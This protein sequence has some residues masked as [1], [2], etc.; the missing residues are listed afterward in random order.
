MYHRHHY[1][2]LALLCTVLIL[3]A[4]AGA[5]PAISQTDVQATVDA[6]VRA[7]LAAQPT[8]PQ[9]PTSP[10]S[11]T[12]IP[13]TATAAPTSPPMAPTVAPFTPATPTETGADTSTATPEATSAPTDTTTV[14]RPA[15]GEA[16]RVITNIQLVFDASGSMA[17]RIGNETK[18]QAAQRAIERIID[19]LPDS[20]DL[21]VGFRVFG[22]EGDS[23]EA[24]KARSCQS[25]AL[26]VPVQGVN[27]E[28][29]RQQARAWKPA[30]WTPI[31]LALQKAGEDL[32]PGEHVRNVIIMVTDG[33]ETCGGDPCAVAKA[34]AESQAEVRIDVVGFGLTPDVAKT[35][36]CVAENSGGVYTDAQDGNALV[37]TL[38]E[39]I[40]ATIK[41]STLRFVPVGIG[42]K[43]EEVALTSLTNV[44]GENVLTA[45]QLPWMARFAR[46][47]VVELPPGEYRF[48]ISYIEIG[49][50]Q[51][52]QH[53]ATTY[54]AI[55]EEG[56][57]TV[58]VI[59]R[60]GVTFVN[61]TP[62]LLRSADLQVEK[63]VNGQWEQSIYPGQMVGI[64]SYFAFDRAFRLTPGRYR[65][66][67]RKRKVVLIDNLIVEPGKEITVRLRGE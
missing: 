38:E 58:A 19:T 16:A 12:T 52:A 17:Q 49:G 11:P 42:G 4:C 66:Y 61:E 32:Q 47:Q 26:L 8:P 15:E 51:I 13:S 25:T 56:R 29:L 64:G 6:G 53:I 57:E 10:P 3:T 35:L 5:P 18:I 27:K 33:E 65:V 62:R 40:A 28:L 24:Q 31:S 55:I 22:H 50:D 1:A 37:Q 39:L 63:A 20:P 60:G 2:L 43:P 45:V 14:F 44:Q 59:G 30:G 46:E 7:T 48:T 54:T 9:S 21:N 67:D 23:S 34:L 36:R 41:R